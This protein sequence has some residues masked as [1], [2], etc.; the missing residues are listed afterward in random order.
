MKDPVRLLD[1]PETSDAA[2]RLLAAGAPTGA[3]PNDVREAAARQLPSG[4]SAA[5]G[6]SAGL[7]LLAGTVIGISAVAIV[8]MNWRGSEP[9]PPAA[10]V[11]EP[12]KIAEAPA[13]TEVETSPPVETRQEPA[14][15]KAKPVRAAP[16]KKRTTSKKAPAPVDVD[17]LAA[18]QRLLSRAR[19]LLK[20]DPTAALAL[21]GEHQRT[22]KDAQLG[23][24]RE[25][26]AVQA[27]DALD[28]S[29]LV[30]ARSARFFEEHPHSPFGREIRAI[31]KRHVEADR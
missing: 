15:Q 17:S 4:P 25:Y 3:I 6:S 19:K 28:A 26:I 9:E 16:E 13:P 30:R 14:P 27:L 20:T 22:F 8:A 5:V 23:D 10:P 2:R 7:K 29:Q 31:A 1:S 24:L 21:A 12:A 18:E 11:V